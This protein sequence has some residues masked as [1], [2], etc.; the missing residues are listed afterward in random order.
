MPVAVQRDGA[1]GRFRHHDSSLPRSASVLLRR[2]R[3][4]LGAPRRMSGQLGKFGPRI[5]SIWRSWAIRGQEVYPT[6]DFG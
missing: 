3:R 5:L 2:R 6:S 4:S 1:P